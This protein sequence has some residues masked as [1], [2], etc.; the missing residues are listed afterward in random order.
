MQKI[1]DAGWRRSTANKGLA[2][3]L[4]SLLLPPAAA[5]AAAAADYYYTSRWSD[6]CQTERN[7][8]AEKGEDGASEGERVEMIT[9][10]M[11]TEEFI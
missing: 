2:E 5:A 7:S 11:F 4:C 8:S 1:Y 6:P 3:N 9:L 10:S